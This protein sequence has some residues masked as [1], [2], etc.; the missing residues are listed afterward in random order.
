MKSD[1]NIYFFHY[2]YKIFPKRFIIFG[3]I[4]PDAMKTKKI[5]FVCFFFSFF[6]LLCEQTFAGTGGAKDGQLMLI[7]IA[8]VL[9][10]IVGILFLFPFLFHQI[11]NIWNKLHHC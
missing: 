9:S 3:V 4:N 10:G 7:V 6:F 8:A 2:T 1:Q 5:Q 11:K